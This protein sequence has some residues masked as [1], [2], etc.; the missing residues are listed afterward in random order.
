MRLVNLQLAILEKLLEQLTLQSLH[1]NISGKLVLDANGTGP[2]AFLLKVYEC[3]LQ[4]FLH[5]P[6]QQSRIFRHTI[7]KSLSTLVFLGRRHRDKNF[8]SCTSA[9]HPTKPLH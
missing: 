3:Q 9:Q 4:N 5:V 7:C 1:A 8:T 2:H 6:A